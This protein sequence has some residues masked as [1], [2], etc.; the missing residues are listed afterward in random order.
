MLK[1]DPQMIAQFVSSPVAMDTEEIYSIATYGSAMA[2]FYTV[3]AIWVGALI[4]VAL[5]H[6][7][8]DGDGHFEKVID[9]YKNVER[10]KKR[11]RQYGSRISAIPDG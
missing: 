3:L 10:L 1:T 6:V 7:D 11:L 9:G 2:P 4:L 5:I 8:V